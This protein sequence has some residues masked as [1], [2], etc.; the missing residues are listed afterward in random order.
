MPSP[1]NNPK[2][3][4]YYTILVNEIVGKDSVATI[5]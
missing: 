4:S 3:F 1:L 2:D 5:T